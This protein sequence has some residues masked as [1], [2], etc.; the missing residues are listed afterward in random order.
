MTIELAE[1]RRECDL[2]SPAMLLSVDDELRSE[3]STPRA[4]REPPGPGPSA[5]V[6]R[7]PPLAAGAGAHSTSQPLVDQLQGGPDVSLPD[8]IAS[9]RLPLQE[10]L[11][12]STPIRRISRRP[13]PPVPRRSVSNCGPHALP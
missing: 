9:L 3:Q 1:P 7:S 11:V 13:S 6:Q 2:N 8:F 4:G 5:G 12:A 10:P